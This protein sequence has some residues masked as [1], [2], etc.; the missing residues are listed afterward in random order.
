L[1]DLKLKRDRIAKMRTKRF[2]TLASMSIMALALIAATAC[3]SDTESAKPASGGGDAGANISAQ[4]TVETEPEQSASIGIPAPDAPNAD[5]MI[6]VLDSALPVNG[7]RDD[8]TATRL[9]DAELFVEGES[10]DGSDPA[11]SDIREL[12]G[13]QRDPAAADDDAAS[14]L[15]VEEV[16]EVQDGSGLINSGLVNP[17]SCDNVLPHAD[18]PM[19]I[20][21]RSATDYASADNPS[22]IAMCMA[23]YAG[24]QDSDSVTVALVAMNSDEAATAHYELLKSEFT[25]QGIAF[26]EQTSGSR[27][28]MTAAIDQEGMGSMVVYR[29]G[30]N[31]ATVHNGPTSDQPVWDD[32]WMLDLAD[33]VLEQLP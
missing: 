3:G 6:V 33:Q 15:P 25:T 21:T 4:S 16:R 17:D 8:S 7:D 28:W 23:W 31:L 22:I 12:R 29:I 5:E 24:P 19:E 26:D 13:P 18:E 32:R 11:T 10:R 2:L 27:D 1:Q 30:S 9:T 14:I 20:K